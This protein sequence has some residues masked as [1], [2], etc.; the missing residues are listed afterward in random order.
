ESHQ[1]KNL[2]FNTRHTRVAGLGNV[3]GSQKAMNLLFAIRT[4][5]DKIQADMGATFLSGT[6]ISNSLTE[7]YLLFKYLRPRALEKQG[8]NCFDA[9]SAIYARKTTDYEFSVAN[10]IVAKE[11][12]RYFIKVPELA[13]FYSEITDYRT[14]KDIGIDR[15]EKNEI[16][17]NIPPTPDQTAF[18]QNLMDFAKSGNATLL[19][20]APLSQREEK[21]KMLIA[22]DYARKMSLDMRMVGGRYDDHPDNKA[23]HCATNIAK[24]Y[25]KFNAQKGTQFIFSDLGT[26]KPGEWNVYSEIKRKLVENHGIPA[27]EVRFI[28]E[29][30]NDN[31]RKGLIKDMNEGKI[32]VIFGSTSM[33]GTGV[34]A[35]KK[36]VAVHHLDT[37]WRPSDLTQRDGRA[38]R[39]G[40]E[41]AKHFANNKVDVIIYATEKSLDSY[42]FNLLYNKQLFIDQLKTNKYKLE[43]VTSML[44]SAQSRLER[45]SLD[46]K[47]LQ[48]RIQKNLDDTI[49]NP[50][51]LDGLL[52]NADMKQIGA[53]LNQIADKFRTGGQYEEIGTLYGFTL[54]VKT[55]ISEKEGVDIRI[56]RFLVQG[57][58]N[59][60]YTYNN[61]IIASDAKLA[62]TNFLN[63]LEKLPGYIEQEQKKITELKKDLPI[64]QEIVKGTWTKESRLSELKTELASID[65]KIQLSITPERKEE[66]AEQTEKQKEV[67]SVSENRV[68]TKGIHLPRGV[69]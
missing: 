60:K 19:G 42:K 54:L 27:H 65:R 37:P 4:I 66:P 67:A 21:A 52:P 15:P 55:E 38:I 12:F 35:Q 53:K 25:N 57:E 22:T 18:I 44:E 17:Y 10:N 26:Y 9:W 40:N 11:R 8:I 39:K 20:R 7:L 63:A 33:L 51:L 49:A 32:R 45:M 46:W 6:T 3:D 41:I 5:Q 28:Q 64:L 1:F 59:I 68:H 43:D 50:V 48:Q 62:S 69:L 29:A 23:S 14:A 16:L 34:N 36:A 58:G 24:Y 2:M 47:N 13:Q 56:N 31:Q 30:K 61:G